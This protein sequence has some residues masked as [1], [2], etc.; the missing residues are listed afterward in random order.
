[1]KKLI[2][3]LCMSAGF[4]VAQDQPQVISVEPK[5]GSRPIQVCSQQVVPV[6]T[7]SAS[8]MGGLLGG[9]VG[10]QIGSGDTRVAS[11]V[12]GSMVGSNIGS[13]YS[14][15]RYEVR[16]ICNTTYETYQLGEVITFMY[17]GRTYTQFTPH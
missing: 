1:M 9:V 15:T 3:I 11:A 13:T 4:A 2:L 16:P 14:D 8:I 7:P 6:R 10:S 5:M 12:I 17:K